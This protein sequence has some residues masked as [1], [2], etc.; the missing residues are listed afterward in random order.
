VRRT[1]SVSAFRR[2]A[3]GDVAGGC[4]LTRIGERPIFTDAGAGF[5]SAGGFVG[6]DFRNM[7]MRQR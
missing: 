7:T 2:V 3:F 4:K 1:A 6:S 5:G